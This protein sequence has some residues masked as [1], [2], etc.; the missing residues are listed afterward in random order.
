VDEIEAA[1]DVLLNCGDLLPA[2]LESELWLFK[3]R[4]TGEQS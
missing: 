4:L 1:V 3:S 2:T